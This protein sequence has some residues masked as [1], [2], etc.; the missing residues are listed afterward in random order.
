MQLTIRITI[1]FLASFGS[2]SAQDADPEAGRNLFVSYCS[3]CHGFD[4]TGVGP[5]AELLAIATPDLTTLAATN[6]GVF[7]TEAVA[8]KIDGR[9]PV[10]AHGGDMPLLGTFFDTGTSVAIRMPDGQSMIMSQT[11]QM[12]ITCQTVLMTRNVNQ[13]SSVCLLLLHHLSRN[14]GSA[15]S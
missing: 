2:V 6:G 8:K 3:Q 10:L 7:P 9:A 14:S 15:N 13:T 12:C 11:M 5:M 4:A 1:V